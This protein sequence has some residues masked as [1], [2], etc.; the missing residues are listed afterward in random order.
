MAVYFLD[1]SAIVKRYVEEAGTDWVIGITSPE[2]DD[3]IYVARITGAE[4]VSAIARRGRGG[5]ISQDDVTRAMADFRHDFALAYHV[6]EITA[7]LITRAMSLAESHA[8]RGYDAV[9]LAA[10]L[11]VND[12]CLD[13]AIPAPTLVSADKALNAAAEAEGLTV[14]DP[15]VH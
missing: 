1:S 4:V 2:K 13:L 5:D 3:S 10:V 8:L 15:N 12:R 9:Q 14:D 6:L 11:E 7:A